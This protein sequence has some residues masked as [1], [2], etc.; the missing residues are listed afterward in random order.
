MI[1]F[2]INNNYHLIMDIKLAE[3]LTDFE[4]G[5]I[6][7]PYS[8]N[9]IN[10]SD[11]FSK[12]FHFREKISLSLRHPLRIFAIQKS[13]DN[14]IKPNCND[15]LLVHTDIDLLNQYIIQRFFEARSRVY[16][17]ED[18]TATMSTYNLI[19]KK[20]SLRNRFKSKIL[21][22]LYNYKFTSIVI[23]G[24]ETLPIIDDRLFTGVIVNIGN[25]IMRNIPLYKLA[26]IKNFIKILYE[27]GAIFF[28]Q[29]FYNVPSTEDEYLLYLRNILDVSKKFTPFYFKFHPS[30]KD[31]MKLSISKLIIENYPNIKIITEEDIAENIIY[32]YP[33]RYAITYN[34]TAAMNLINNGIV[35]IFLNNLLCEK[36]PNNHFNGFPV[37]LKSVNWHI[38]ASLA[39]VEPGF[40]TFQETIEENTNT[41]SILDILNRNMS[42]TVLSI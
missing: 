14:E 2:L 6:Q 23:Y 38:P 7:I 41:H 42:K 25:K 28:H 10:N 27:N 15:I 5:L 40:C 35:P 18:G 24:M 17:L 12:I 20:A 32:K 19:A 30:E 26:P 21:K 16:L 29:P 36:F 33:V 13:F 11:I 1:Y 9:E 22:Y 8:L 39:E 34:S 4:L 31:T 37:F 3:Q